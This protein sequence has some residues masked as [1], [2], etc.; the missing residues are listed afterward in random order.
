M[1]M[2]HSGVSFILIF[3]NCCD[4]ADMFDGLSK[5]RWFEVSLYQRPQ[6]L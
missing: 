3:R 1:Y 5:M 2:F 4:N 6:T